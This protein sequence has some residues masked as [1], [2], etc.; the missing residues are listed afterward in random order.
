DVRAE[1]AFFDKFVELTRGVTSILIS[2]RFSSVRRADHIVVIDG[3]RVSEQGSHAELMAA[4][5][6]YARLFTLQAER[7]AKGLDADG[8]V[9]DDAVDID[10]PVV[11]MEE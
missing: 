11:L 7:F 10:A 4:G 8:E 1:V 5:G 2:H 6:H 3:G 9:V